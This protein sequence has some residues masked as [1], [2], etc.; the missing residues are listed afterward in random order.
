MVLGSGQGGEYELPYVLPSEKE[1]RTHRSRKQ[2][3][4]NDVTTV[5]ANASFGIFQINVAAND[6]HLR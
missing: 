2:V 6:D 5:Q 3:N 1:R 4:E